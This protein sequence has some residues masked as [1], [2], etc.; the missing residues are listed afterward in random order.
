MT[1][2]MGTTAT[3][4]K[5]CMIDPYCKFKIMASDENKNYMSPAYHLGQG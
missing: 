3:I 4:N 2:I 1:N 5:K